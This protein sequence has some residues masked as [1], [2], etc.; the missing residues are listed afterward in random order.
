MYRFNSE[1]TVLHQ[2]KS[3][4]KPHRP[5]YPTMRR[6]FL[7]IS[8]RFCWRL[9]TR[10]PDELKLFTAPRWWAEAIRPVEKFKMPPGKWDEVWLSKATSV[11][12]LLADLWK[13]LREDL[14]EIWKQAEHLEADIERSR[15]MLS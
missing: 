7:E 3:A 14:T 8:D 4:L 11:R 9:W 12:N 1:L 15:E 2:I 6:I 5:F 10:A 13:K